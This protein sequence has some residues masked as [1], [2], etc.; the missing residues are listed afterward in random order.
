ME[1][2]E[3]LDAIKGLYGQQSYR[4]L[5][6]L[7]YAVLLIQIFKINIFLGICIC[8]IIFDLIC[9][10]TKLDILGRHAVQELQEKEKE[11]KK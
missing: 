11:N 2:E 5:K 3:L 1:R 7:I 4:I 9:K 6:T 10:S 8:M